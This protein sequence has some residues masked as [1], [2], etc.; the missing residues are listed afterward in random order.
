MPRYIKLN[1]EILA[2]VIF[3]S[4]D[5]ESIEFFSPPDFSQQIG[6]IHRKANY[7]VPLHKHNEISREVL[8]TQEVLV[9]RTGSCEI[10]LQKDS[11]REKVILRSGDS[12][13]L[14]SGAHE[15]RF[16][17]DTQLLEIKQGPYLGLQDKEILES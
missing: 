14:A 17:E 12:I 16:I 5:V 15:I 1:D 9:V 3:A 11:I 2:I 7:V 13:L 10:T 4:E 8:R 6:L